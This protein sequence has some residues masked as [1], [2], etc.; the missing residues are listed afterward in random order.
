MAAIEF[1][2]IRAASRHST[3]PIPMFKK[4]EDLS[5]PE[6][7]ALV[8]AVIEKGFR[9]PLS[10][11]S[12]EQNAGPAAMPAAGLRRAPVFAEAS[13]RQAEARPAHF[14]PNPNPETRHLKPET[15]LYRAPPKTTRQPVFCV[16]T[17]DKNRHHKQPR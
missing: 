13:P 10:G 6:T 5:V 17:I 8:N 15:I 16:A 2:A 12:D 11:V 14:F 7:A 4:Y 1:R 3:D 9:C